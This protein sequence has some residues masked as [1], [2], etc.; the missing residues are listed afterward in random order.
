MK[1]KPYKRVNK[2]ILNVIA[3]QKIKRRTNADL[4]Q[5]SLVQQKKQSKSPQDRKIYSCDFIGCKEKGFKGYKELQ[6]HWSTE[7]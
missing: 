7:C 3:E 1:F 2:V 5:R 4:E 6:K